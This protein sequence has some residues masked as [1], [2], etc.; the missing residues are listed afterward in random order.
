MSKSE[1]ENARDSEND[2]PMSEMDVS[3]HCEDSFERGANW[4]YD[5]CDKRLYGGLTKREYF[6]GLAMQGFCSLETYDL[7]PK[8]IANMAEALEKE[9]IKL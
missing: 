5:W 2:K 9:E 3:F 6:A 8:N 4:A 1:F 7:T